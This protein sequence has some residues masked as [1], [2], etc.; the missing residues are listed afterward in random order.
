MNTT[1][2]YMNVIDIQGWLNRDKAAFHFGSFF[3]Q[4]NRNSVVFYYLTNYIIY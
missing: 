1:C 2:V 3:R 4:I